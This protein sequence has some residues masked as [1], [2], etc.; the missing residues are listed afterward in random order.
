VPYFAWPDGEYV[1]SKDA[2]AV[3]DELLEP[4]RGPETVRAGNIGGEIE[5]AETILPGTP[6]WKVKGTK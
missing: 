1:E 6:G 4:L 5:V 2:A 3:A